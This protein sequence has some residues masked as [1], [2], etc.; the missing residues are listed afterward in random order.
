MPCIFPFVQITKLCMSDQLLL[1]LS[2]PL[3]RSPIFAAYHKYL[4]LSQLHQKSFTLLTPN[5]KLESF[6]GG[7]LVQQ[8]KLTEIDF[9]KR[10]GIFKTTLSMLILT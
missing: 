1:N 9:L 6:D 2:H 3:Y 4:S 10:K 7:S 5:L 8:I